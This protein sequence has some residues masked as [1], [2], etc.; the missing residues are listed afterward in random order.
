LTNDPDRFRRWEHDRLSADIHT[1]TNEIAA[2]RQFL[3]FPA[4]SITEASERLTSLLFRETLTALTTLPVAEIAE[5][6]ERW[7]ARATL[8]V[9]SPETEVLKRCRARLARLRRRFSTF[10]CLHYVVRSIELHIEHE[11]RMAKMHASIHKSDELFR[12]IRAGLA[13]SGIYIGDD[14]DRIDPPKTSTRDEQIAAA[15]EPGLIE[16]ADFIVTKH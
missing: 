4:A 16:L 11:K 15:D 9:Q 6:M 7:L 3:A 10:D 5:R 13:E 2:L 1:V 14:G 12:E 8:D